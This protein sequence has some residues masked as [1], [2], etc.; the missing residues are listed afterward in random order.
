MAS[1]ERL[2]TRSAFYRP[3]DRRAGTLPRVHAVSLVLTPDGPGRPLGEE[4]F[5]LTE[6]PDVD[7]V[8]LR[9]IAEIRLAPWL[10]AHGIF[11]VG[12]DSG[13]PPEYLVPVAEPRDILPDGTLRPPG[14]WALVTTSQKPPPVILEHLDRNL[15]L[16]PPR[17]QRDTLR[18]LPP[19]PFAGK[20]PLDR[21]A[22]VVPRI[23]RRLTGVRLPAGR[24]PANHQLVVLSGVRV[25]VMLRMLRD[26][27]VQWQA[28]TLSLGVDSGYRS[29]TAELLRRLVIPR[30][31]LREAHARRVLIARFRAAQ[32]RMRDN[33]KKPCSG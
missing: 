12:P 7:G 9:E 10:G 2:D 28:D 21:D 30:R 16:M 25:A 27:L 4:P 1:A 26:P 20:L 8:P 22:V 11:T 17:G 19:E 13:L 18:W 6:V 14:K 33:S 24:L 3:K 31:H 5:R 15:H 23:A 32:A 29:Y